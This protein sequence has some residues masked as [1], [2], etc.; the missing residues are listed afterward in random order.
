MSCG[1][2][3]LER[4]GITVDTYYASEIK[5]SAIKVA[6]EKLSRYNSYRRCHEGQLQRWNITYGKWRF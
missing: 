3:A 1:R 6:I 2:I 4:A 5:K